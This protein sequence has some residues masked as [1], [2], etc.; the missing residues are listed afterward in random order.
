MNIEARWS[1]P[2]AILARGLVLRAAGAEVGRMYP[3]QVGSHAPKNLIRVEATRWEGLTAADS[4]AGTAIE[5]WVER[6]GGLR[7][8]CTLE[9]VSI[10]RGG[11][12]PP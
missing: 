7:P 12:L 3:V 9:Q 1:E 2:G 10:S 11:N 6:P 5:V 8:L 4:E